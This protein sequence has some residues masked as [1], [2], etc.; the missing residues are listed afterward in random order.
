MDD[1][2]KILKDLSS[3]Y[4]SLAFSI[5]NQTLSNTDLK[6]AFEFF[7]SFNFDRDRQN[8]KDVETLDDTNLMKF[9]TL[10]WFIY[11]QLTPFP[12]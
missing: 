7:V 8:E 4:S 5:E 3:F 1:K 12:E 2:T 11:T 6:K 9:F 10:G